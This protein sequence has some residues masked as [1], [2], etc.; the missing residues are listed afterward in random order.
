MPPM[1]SL[2]AYNS[3]SRFLW[4]QLF[5]LLTDTF[6]SLSIQTELFLLLH[7]NMFYNYSNYCYTK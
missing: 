3:Q 1:N 7:L 4:L 6:S 5:F 2:F